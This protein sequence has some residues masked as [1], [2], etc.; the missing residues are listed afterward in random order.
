MTKQHIICGR[1]RS[2]G[3]IIIFGFN[4]R[5]FSD[6][7]LVEETGQSPFLSKDSTK[8]QNVRSNKPFEDATRV[9]ASNSTILHRTFA[10]AAMDVFIIAEA[11]PIFCTR[12]ALHVPE[13]KKVNHFLIQISYRMHYY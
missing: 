8:I 7:I 6:R 12:I 5:D 10:I 9:A 4:S 3:K 13:K 2:K 11:A 1:C